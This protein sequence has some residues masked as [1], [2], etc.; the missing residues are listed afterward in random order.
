[1]TSDS[2]SRVTRSKRSLGLAIALLAGVVVAVTGL[3][4]QETPATAQPA[5]ATVPGNAPA[6]TG[7]ETAP[8]PVAKG[9]ASALPQTPGSPAAQ[10][11]AVSPP[12]PADAKSPPAGA[13]RGTTGG[14]S[15]DRFEPTEKVR[16]DYDVSF[17]VDI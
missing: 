11:P 17:P 15:K 6:S 2:G 16:A 7:S 1:M 3:R 9:N 4:A 14:G 12:Q 10:A 13:S 5:P 8:S